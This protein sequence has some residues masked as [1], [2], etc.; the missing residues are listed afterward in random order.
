MAD[1]P[2]LS[3]LPQLLMLL[4]SSVLVVLLFRRLRL[5]P[6]LG[7]LAVGMLLGPYA[8]NFTAS[9]VAPIL[10]DLGVVFLVFTLGLE[11]SLP[12]MIAM[13]REAFLIGGLQVVLTTATFATVLWTLQ[14]PPL[15]SVMIGGALAMSSTAIVIRQLGEQAELNRTH[16][17]IAIGI[18]LFQ[19]LAFV[20]LLALESALAGAGAERATWEIAESILQ[21]AVA[22]ALVLTF[23]RWLVRPLFHEIG[24]A[25]STELFTLATLMVA[26]GAAWATHAVGLSLALGGFLAGM[27]LAETEY[28][29]QLETV[30]RPFR[31]VLIGL[32][33]ITIGTLLDLQLLFRQW[34]LVLLLVVGLQLAKMIIVTIVA[35]LGTDQSRKALRVGVV[36]AQGGEFGFALLTLMLSDRLADSSLIQP[37]LAATVVS[38]VL[39]PL[40]IRHNDQLAELVFPRKTPAPVPD[41]AQL[42]GQRDHVIICGFGRVGQ[43]LARV[44]ERQG[45]VYVALDSDP[46]AVELARRAGDP[47]IFGDGTATEMLEAVGLERCRVLVLTF[48]EATASMKIVKAV[49]EL[50]P[51][52]PILVRTQDDTKLEELQQ[53][54]A[55]EIVPETLEASLMLVS[56]VLLLLDVPVSRVVKTVGDIRNNRYA[57]LRRLFRRDDARMVDDGD[58]GNEELHTV[59]LPP[60]AYCVGKTLADLKLDSE[61]VTVTAI[62]RDGILGQQPTPTTVLREGD[63][64]ILAG[65]PEALENGEARLLMG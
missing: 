20:P 55:T 56:H 10:A 46:R 5:P 19:D 13:R 14:V 2:D 30:I 49:R 37:L 62:R 53:A 3:I 28:R 64:V 50:R 60:G 22:L 58:T 42:A 44:L 15:T 26:V 18:L 65:A 63:V 47:V 43:N 32:F 52:L 29:H 11:F 8:L 12:R 45:F 9:G 41:Q 39:S 36:M 27:L 33:F 4:A 21:A 6:I 1:H 35:R 34:W 59:V 54:G 23:L 40:L 25:R 38:M 61:D 48:A 31:D 16:S 57:M 24:R 17:R 7:Y 51:D